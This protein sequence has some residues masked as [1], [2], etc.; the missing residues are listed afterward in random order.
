MPLSSDYATPIEIELRAGRLEQICLG[1]SAACA[2]AGLLYAELPMPVRL[3]LLLVLVLMSWRAAQ[4]I[5]N[6]T[7]V[8]IFYADGLVAGG[9]HDEPRP[10]DLL[11]A[12]GYGPAL[13]L[14]YRDAGCVHALMLFP[15]RVPADVGQR[16]RLWL[17]A[18]R[19]QPLGAPA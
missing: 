5:G 10:V 1:L 4:M 11:Q 18:H 2:L 17:A 14:C 3:S 6:R 12:S 9:S 8:L 13:L 19:P 7:G 15:D 16:I